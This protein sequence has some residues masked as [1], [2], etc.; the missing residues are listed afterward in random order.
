MTTL[1]TTQTT[2]EAAQPSASEGPDRGFRLADL[3]GNTELVIVI[4]L[5]VASVFTA[6]ATFQAALYGGMTDS[7]YAKGQSAQTEAE[8]LYLEA[9]QL[10]VQDVQT[11]ARLTELTVD[12][13]NPDPAIAAAAST[14]FDT[15][16]FVSVDE[17][18]D[19]AMIWSQEQDAADGYVGPFDSEEYFA[20]RFGAWQEQDSAS[21]AMIEEG[22]LYNAYSDRLE[23]NTTLMAITLF[24]LGVAAV[25]KRRRTQWTLIA[26][27]SG[28]F[29]IAAVLTA[30]VPVTWLG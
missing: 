23:L 3:F 4:L 15:L 27:G 22:D 2:P 1:D 14:K 19:A 9:N 5:G 12:M 28:I 21:A 24:L 11:F 20:A 30:I 8:S 6:W 18:L 25:V 16:H 29:A 10:F 26:F 13:E 7:S 17:V